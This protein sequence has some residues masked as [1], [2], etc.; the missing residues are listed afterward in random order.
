[1]SLAKRCADTLQYGQIEDKY[2]AA[3]YLIKAKIHYDHL[4]GDERN[5]VIKDL[6]YEYCLRY[7]LK[8]AKLGKMIGSPS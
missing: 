3:T 7:N 6:I 5:K 4:K 8:P 2:E 1:M